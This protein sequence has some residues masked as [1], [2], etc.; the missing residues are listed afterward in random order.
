MKTNDFKLIPDIN[1]L[2]SEDVLSLVDSVFEKEESTLILHL[3]SSAFS[4]VGYSFTKDNKKMKEMYSDEYMIVASVG[5]D[6]DR[7]GFIDFI[8]YM[9]NKQNI[10][11]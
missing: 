9:C 7:D 5:D 3:K 1:L 2:K 8:K 10:K 11:F 4:V 6:V